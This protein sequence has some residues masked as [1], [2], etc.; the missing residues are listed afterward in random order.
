MRVLINIESIWIWFWSHAKLTCFFLKT[1]VQMA[2]DSHS[3]CD[4]YESECNTNFLFDVFISNSIIKPCAIYSNL[5]ILYQWSNLALRE[6]YNWLKSIPYHNDEMYR[7]VGGC[8]F[9]AFQATIEL[10]YHTLKSAKKPWSQVRRFGE[11]DCALFVTMT[12]TCGGHYFNFKQLSDEMVGPI[13]LT[14][15]HAFRFLVTS[16]FQ[17]GSELNRT[18]LTKMKLTFFLLV[19]TQYSTSTKR[20]KCFTPKLYGTG[21]VKLFNQKL[22]IIGINKQ[23]IN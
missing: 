10:K 21:G 17:I 20:Y 7:L 5:P 19:L 15:L 14:R 11:W 1:K 18:P 3:H 2:F 4:C 13:P 22:M 23:R 9:F 8:S 16:S 12:L 6:L